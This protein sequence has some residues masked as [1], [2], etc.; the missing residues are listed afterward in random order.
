MDP[1]E[2]KNE[3]DCTDSLF[4][5]VE[6]DLMDKVAGKVVQWGMS[7]PAILFLESGKPLNFVTSQLMQFFHP[8]LSV[9]IDTSQY[10]KFAELLEKRESL[11]AIVKVIEQKES[12]KKR[13]DHKS[14][15]H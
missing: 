1:N 8:F 10:G 2:Q 11:E 12:E 9:F 3:K 13:E 5:P 14:E 4:D 7:V 6:L 15:K